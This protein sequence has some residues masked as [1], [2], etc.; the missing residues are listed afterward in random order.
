MLTV[1]TAATPTHKDA[2]A[3]AADGRGDGRPPAAL[4]S[5]DILTATM[6]ILGGVCI[7]S[8]PLMRMFTEA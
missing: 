7:P 4:I 5:A 3:G 1:F 2:T 6:R 8:D